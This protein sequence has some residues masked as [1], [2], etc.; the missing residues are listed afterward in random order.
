MVKGN[1]NL[2]IAVFMKEIF[3]ITK[4]VDMGNILGVME[5]HILV[6]G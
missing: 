6:I 5:K 2:Q 3:W 1:F 4:L